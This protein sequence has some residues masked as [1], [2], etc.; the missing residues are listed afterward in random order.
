MSIVKEFREFAVKGNV[1]D[2]AVAVIIGG[3]FGKIVTSVVEDLVMPPLGYALG[4]A[5]FANLFYTFPGQEEKIAKAKAAT[6]V[7]Y[8]AAGVATL[9]YGNFLNIVIQFLIIA[10]CVFVMVRTINHI[11][12][13]EPEIKSEPTTKECPFCLSEVPL[14]ATKCKNCASVF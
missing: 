9:N 7:A 3:A 8:K 2:L 14:A 12:P 13:K 5:D 10:L 6:L 4:R 1:V 11:K